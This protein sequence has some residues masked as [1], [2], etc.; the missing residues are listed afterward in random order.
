M[1]VRSLGYQTFVGGIL[2]AVLYLGLVFQREGGGSTVCAL[3]QLLADYKI[4]H[5]ELVEEGGIVVLGIEGSLGQAHLHHGPDFVV[6]PS[7]AIV[8]LYNLQETRVV[9][10]AVLL[11]FLGLVYNGVQLVFNLLKPPRLDIALGL[12]I[13]R[14][15]LTQFLASAARSL[16]E[17]LECGG[18]KCS[19]FLQL[20][21]QNLLAELVLVILRPGTV[22][23]GILSQ[24]ALE[25]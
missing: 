20:H 5:R 13:F 24:Q 15:K 4:H 25:F 7:F 9:D 23:L 17:A 14:R 19:D 10:I 1:K 18:L 21:I 3:I 22:V 2:L 6:A 12:S 8:L 11:Q 16:L